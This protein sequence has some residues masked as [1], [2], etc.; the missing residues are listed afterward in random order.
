MSEGKRRG[1]DDWDTLLQLGKMALSQ[2][3]QKA[4]ELATEVSRVVK[5]HLDPNV[6][7]AADVRKKY[8]AFRAAGFSHEEAQSYTEKAMKE[9]IRKG[10]QSEK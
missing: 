4:G 6:R 5:E 8:D 9:A 3:Q 10:T 1:G 2:A 7:L